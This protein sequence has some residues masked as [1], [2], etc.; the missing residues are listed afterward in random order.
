MKPPV[1]DKAAWKVPAAKCKDFI[2][3]LS[4][5]LGRSKDNDVLMYDEDNNLATNVPEPDDEGEDINAIKPQGNASVLASAASQLMSCNGVVPP[6]AYDSLDWLAEMRREDIRIQEEVRK[7]WRHYVAKGKTLW[8]SLYDALFDVYH[9]D[10]PALDIA[11][12]CGPG[13]EHQQYRQRIVEEFEW[14][15]DGMDTD[16]S[17]MSKIFRASEVPVHQIVAVGGSPVP[18]GTEPVGVEILTEWVPGA[19]ITTVSVPA[20]GKLMAT[21]SFRCNILNRILPT[22]DGATL[23]QKKMQH[24]PHPWSQIAWQQWLTA[25]RAARANGDS[26]AKVGNLRT[27]YREHIIDPVTLALANVAVPEDT[28]AE[29]MRFYPGC[30]DFFALLASPNINGVARLLMEYRNALGSKTIKYISVSNWHHLD[31]IVELEPFDM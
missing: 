14:L 10:R 6:G 9:K 28:E 25:C 20:Q 26:S 2:G 23:A 17:L 22:D 15:D 8:G 21:K 31:I 5:K 24:C 27:V 13:P 11:V 29:W 16:N 1:F 12:F 4:A 3:R 19:S 30:D 18:A 7:S